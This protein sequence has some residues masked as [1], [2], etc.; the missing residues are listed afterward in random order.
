MK[1]RSFLLSSVFAFAGLGLTACEDVSLGEG[2]F[3]GADC[4]EPGPGGLAFWDGVRSLPA[5]STIPLSPFVASMPGSYEPLPGQCLTDFEIRPESAGRVERNPA[6]GFDLVVSEDAPLG[7]RTI[8]SAQYR[9]Q[10]VRARFAVYDR[11]QSPLVGYWRQRRDGCPD[12][13]AIEELIFS[14]DGSFSVTWQP[15]EVYK[16]YWGDY[17][18]DP[19]TGVLTLDVESGNHDGGGVQSGTITLNG[20]QMTLGSVSFGARY[21]GQP[22]C[23]ADFER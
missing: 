17:S 6:G 18:F 14:A 16:D 8:V 19:Q 13:T 22:E 23:R 21:D 9:G 15:F 2:L 5:G 1:S 4:P 11:A 12:G 10:S 3:S 20:D 7:E